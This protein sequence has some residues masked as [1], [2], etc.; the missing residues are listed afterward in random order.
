MANS[1]T[2]HVINLATDMPS[3]QLEGLNSEQAAQAFYTH[4][5]VMGVTMFDASHII[6]NLLKIREDGVNE[7]LLL[8]IAFTSVFTFNQ[9]F[10]G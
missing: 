8:K 4:L 7:L 9:F 6:Q 1:Y 5:L 3:Q 2:V 10:I